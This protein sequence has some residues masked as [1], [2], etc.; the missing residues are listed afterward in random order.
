MKISI[1]TVCKNSENHI[2]KSIQSVT[3][4][5][6]SNYEY[7]IIDGKSEDGTCAIIAKYSKYIDKFISELD[8]GIYEAMNKGIK[9]STGDFLFFLNSDDYLFDPYVIKDVV[10][11]LSKYDECDFIYGNVERIGI[12]GE[13]FMN[14]SPKPEFL[15]EGMIF[16][17]AIPHQGSFFKADLFEKLGLFDE[18]YRIAADYEWFT[19]LLKDRSLKLI[20]SDRVISSYSCAGLSGVNLK[21]AYREMF[22][23]QN[24]S[25]LFDSTDTEFRLNRLQE[26]CME[27]QDLVGKL[28]TLAEE[29]HKYA[30]E[31]QDLVG[32]LQTLAEER[33]KYAA[34]TKN[35]LDES[36]ILSNDRL[37]FIQASNWGKL[38][39]LVKKVIKLFKRKINYKL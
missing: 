5:I 33:H 1:I 26:F 25:G 36:L 23:A 35:Y 15:K 27:Q 22:D 29:R 18:T 20:F 37:V 14:K 6:Y 11:T 3:S 34:E 16:S 30:V 24:K 32:K 28:Q 19:R 7:I 10:Q 39:L 2:E 4:Q 13:S 21:L 8:G 38:I 31:Q 9:L 17:C 12:S